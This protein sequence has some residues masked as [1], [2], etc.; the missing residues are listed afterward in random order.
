MD[1]LLDSHALLWFINRDPHLSRTAR[2]AIEDEDAKVFVSIASIWEI[3][4]KIA[5]GKLKLELELERELE[6]FLDQNGFNLLAIDYS[7]AARVAT[8][9]HHHGDPF[10]RLLVSQSLIEKMT[11]ISHDP[12]LDAYGIKRVW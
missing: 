4:I 11:L 1:L 3:A 8:L 2:A 9:P 5:L 6:D 7:H 12:Q 10:D